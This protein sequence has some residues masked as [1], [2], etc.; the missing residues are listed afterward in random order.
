[1]ADAPFSINPALTAIAVGYK[2]PDAALI[3]DQ[4]LPRVPT[5]ETFNYT[6]YNTAQAYTLP[7][8][9]VGRRSAPN[10]VTFGGTSVTD[11]VKDYGLDDP[12]PQRDIEAFNSMPKPPTGGPLDPTVLS[13]MML[14]G[15]ID[16]A[17]EI[18]VADVVFNASNY[19]SS[20]QTTL[21]G[22]SQWSDFVNSDPLSDLLGALDQPLVRP[23]TL[24]LGQDVWT[25]LRQHPKMVQAI[26]KTAQGAGSVS[27]QQVA[28]LLEIRQILVGAGWVNTA[29]RGQAPSFARVW[30]KNAALIYASPGAAQTFQPVWGWT[31][32]WGGKFAGTIQDVKQGLKGSV[33][34]RVGE[35][36]KELVSAPDA[37]YYFA[38]AVA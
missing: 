15:L 32:A 14:S 22:T 37:G 13:T 34:V 18:R 23:D 25:K 26:F 21:S 16:L 11:T 9:E 5:A 3:A 29:R 2:N 17:R 31:A 35:Q 20:K 19:D 7:P 33:T 4:A 27:K 1:M 28:D 8:T 10:I 24:V 38:A 6:V 30:G 12:I 36:L